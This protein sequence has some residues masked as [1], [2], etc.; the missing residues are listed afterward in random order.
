MPYKYIDN[1][2]YMYISTNVGTLK[3]LA[4]FSK[5]L[6]QFCQLP[7]QMQAFQEQAFLINFFEVNDRNQNKTK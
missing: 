7:N 3:N 4:N 6:T 1:I 5:I 2:K